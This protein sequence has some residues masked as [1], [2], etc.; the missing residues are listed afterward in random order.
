MSERNPL[1]VFLVASPQHYKN[2]LESA[3]YKE[4]S[5]FLLHRHFNITRGSILPEHD[6]ELT[7]M[8]NSLAA[9][10][11]LDVMRYRAAALALAGLRKDLACGV[12][13]ALRLEVAN[14]RSTL[15]SLGD[16][17][18]WD[19]PYGVVGVLAARMKGAGQ[20]T[21]LYS[22]FAA[23]GHRGEH[24]ATQE[25]VEEMSATVIRGLVQRWKKDLLRGALRAEAA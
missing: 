13:A 18:Y 2:H 8:L 5:A 11:P 23:A 19:V 15:P 25:Q 7:T 3:L 9:T 21:M 12:D 1:R 22:A 4:L 10:D 16:R 24:G 14:T 17:I 20:P 6:P